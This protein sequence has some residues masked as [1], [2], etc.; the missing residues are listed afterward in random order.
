MSPSRQ[1]T[2]RRALLALPAL[3]ALAMPRILR[4]ATAAWPGDQPVQVVVPFPPGG[5]VDQMARMVL[6]YVQEALREG[7]G[8]GGS[9]V[10][11]N[12]PGAGSQIG[13]EYVF[14]SKPDGHTL[15]AVTAP[16][17]TTIAMER[18]VRYEAARFGFIANVAD[19]PGGL[20]V[21]VDSRF[22]TLDDLMRAARDKPDTLSLGT[23]GIGSDDHLMQL[24]VQAVAKGARF[25]H[26]PYAGSAP[27]QTALLG[28]HLDVGCFNMSEG[29]GNLRAGKL[30]ALAQGGEARWAAV[31]D[32]ATLREAG[33]PVT[34]GAQ[35]GIVAPPG[36]PEEITAR[37]VE[38]FGKALAHPRFQ[39]DAA[40]VDMPLK[41]LLGE[42]YR[43]VITA[44]ASRWQELWQ[45]SPWREG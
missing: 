31:P 9:F 1:T 11:E 28:G 43:R 40:R 8:P 13:M 18:P 42:D 21:A 39:A 41:P 45:Q 29:I 36:V 22:R 14:N 3:A 26:V 25:N 35:R 44:Q 27:L 23:T 10:V 34:A 15:C 5:G 19:D 17:I 12:R 20:W 38:A 37:M 33:I 30:R 4:A 24:E 16:A 2:P 7:G 32:V 6:P